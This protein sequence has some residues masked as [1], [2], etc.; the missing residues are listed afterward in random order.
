M[1]APT[2]ARTSQRL[3]APTSSG[4]TLTVEYLVPSSTTSSTYPLQVEFFLADAD[5]QE[6]Q[7]FLGSDT[8]DLGEAGLPQTKVLSPSTALSPGAKLVATATDDAGNTSEFSI[9]S[10]LTVIE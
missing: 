1:A 6:G 9:S 3:P 4:E 8:Y 10:A 5:G 7:T 2:I